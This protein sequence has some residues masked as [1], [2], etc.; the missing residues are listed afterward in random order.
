MTPKALLINTLSVSYL[1]CATNVVESAALLAHRL[2]P[3]WVFFDQSCLFDHTASSALT[4]DAITPSLLCCVI[5]SSRTHG[6][7]DHIYRAGELN[8][9]PVAPETG[10]I[11]MSRKHERCWKRERERGNEFNTRRTENMDLG[12]ELC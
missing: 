4:S 6:G 3:D 12:A 5:I 7:R 2:N 1:T 10:F 8:Q 9:Q 11:N